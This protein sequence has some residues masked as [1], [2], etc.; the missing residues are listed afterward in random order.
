MAGPG[1]PL[2]MGLEASGPSYKPK[3]PMAGFQGNRVGYLTVQF[4]VVY[5]G[6]SLFY[7]GKEKRLNMGFDSLICAQ[8]REFT[9]TMAVSHCIRKSFIRFDP[10]MMLRLAR[11]L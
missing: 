6:H 4:F 9:R 11:A 5:G 3:P 10:V 2:T 1:S 7:P 8:N